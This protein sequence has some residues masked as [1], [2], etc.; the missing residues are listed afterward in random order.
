[1]GKT[2][3]L[4][5]HGHMHGVATLNGPKQEAST[6]CNSKNNSINAS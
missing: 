4:A 5:L 2:S 3:L 1:M 6:S